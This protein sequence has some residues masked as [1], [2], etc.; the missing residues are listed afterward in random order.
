MSKKPPRAQPT[1][2][3]RKPKTP[4]PLAAAAAA[5]QPAGVVN[6]G[7]PRP[8]R[9]IDVTEF[10]NRLHVAHADGKGKFAFFLGA[11]CSKSSGIPLAGELVKDNWLPRLHAMRK[12]HEKDVTTWATTCFQGYDPKNAALLY[13][14]VMAELFLTPDDRQTEIET[15]CDSRTPAFGYAVLAQMVASETGTFNIVLTT[16]FD[17]LVADALYLYTPARPLVIHHESLAEYIRPT[18]TRPLIVKLHGDHRLSPHNTT[19]ET[20]AIAKALADQTKSLLHD[21]GLI[22]IGYSGSD[23]GILQMLQQLPSKALPHGAFWV[24][25]DEPTGPI[26]DWL[27]ERDGIWVKSGWFDEVMLLARDAMNLE[28]PSDKR[29]TDIFAKYHESFRELSAKVYSKPATDPNAAALQSAAAQA[30]STFPN[31]WKAM[32]EADRHEAAGEMDRAEEV[33]RAGITQFPRAVPLLD[34]FAI[35]LTNIR[36]NHDAA[37]AMFKRAIEADPKRAN[38]LGNYALFLTNIRANHDAAE[39]L[40]KRAIEANPKYFN[41]LGNYATFLTDVRED[42]DA[43]EAMYKRAI[44]ADPKHAD[45][46]GNYALFLAHAR[47]DHDAAEAMYKRALEASP[48]HANTL[49]NYANFLANIRKDQNAADAL[50]ARLKAIE[51]GPSE[52]SSRPEGR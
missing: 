52:A 12:P 43:A 46:L 50:R 13:G 9:Q 18:R 34:N 6:L 11:G 31:F 49:R 15:L 42:H 27:I 38:S 20:S 24:H 4:P 8:I 2:R 28:H 47:K 44:E 30:E 10:V 26:R 7:K 39:A 51:K 1:T 40:Y 33:Y 37:E 14:R 23:T 41:A 16:N 25:P 35:F 17:D 29:F 32:A 19:T 3:H 48:K 45:H 36:K 5:P 21:R 22:F